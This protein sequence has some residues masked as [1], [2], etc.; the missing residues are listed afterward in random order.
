MT[1]YI[2]TFQILNPVRRKKIKEHLKT[3][4]S[5]CPIHQNAWAILTDKKST[6][7]RNSIIKLVDEADRIFIIRSG[8]ESAWYNIYGKL[9]TEWLQKNL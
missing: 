9:N 1:T 4:S 5:Y 7:I 8:T 6:D 2:V 3:Y